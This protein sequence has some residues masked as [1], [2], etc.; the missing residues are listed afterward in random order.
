MIATRW[1]QAKQTGDDLPVHQDQPWIHNDAKCFRSRVHLLI[2]IPLLPPPPNLFVH[3]FYLFKAEI[4]GLYQAWKGKQMLQLTTKRQKKIHRLLF[5]SSI[6][7]YSRDLFSLFFFFLK[8][9]K[10]FSF[11]RVF[12][13]FFTPTDVLSQSVRKSINP[14]NIQHSRSPSVRQRSFWFLIAAP[15]GLRMCLL[16]W[17]SF[18]FLSDFNPSTKYFRSFSTRECHLIFDW[19]W[20]IRQS[21]FKLVYSQKKDCLTFIKGAH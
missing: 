2:S 16:N 21:L 15:E 13:F 19:D 1:G 12:E 7:V 4:Y 11:L 20:Q 10:S 14:E 9:I 5:Y 17:E 6:F 8:E 3:V 18:F